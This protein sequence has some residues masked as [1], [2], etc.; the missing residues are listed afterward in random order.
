MFISRLS[1]ADVALEQILDRVREFTLQIHQCLDLSEILRLTVQQ[2]REVLASDRAA[3]YRFLPDGD[4]V[5]AEESVSHEW[6]P[7]LGQLIYDPCFNA[8]WMEQYQKGRIGI[9]EDIDA[10][11]LKPCYKNLLT[12]LQIR[13]NLVVPILLTRQQLPEK[14][15]AS[16]EIW[17][18]LI[19]HQC[20]SPRHW[21]SLEIK[22]LQLIAAQLGIALQQLEIQQQLRQQNKSLEREQIIFQAHQ[23]IEEELRGQEALLRS[24]TDSS[25][26]GFYVVNNRNDEILYFNHR[27]CEIWGIE[28]LAEKIG[29]CESK[30]ND[31]IPDCVR[32][33]ADA[34]KIP[35]LETVPLD[36]I[37]AAD[38]ALYQAKSNGRNRFFFDVLS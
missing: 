19:V 38:R 16:S 25:Q 7:I 10:Q 27:F 18:L 24:M 29:R 1:G 4:G 28:H 15:T 8:E 20:S 26:L 6:Q 32:L 14:A 17:G 13:A 11:P 22:F 31:I 30:N 5:V 3:I 21:N 33:I 23:G 12:S 9:L 35:N 37:E 34:P 2:V 36:L